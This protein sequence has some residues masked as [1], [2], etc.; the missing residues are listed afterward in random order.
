MNETPSLSQ[1]VQSAPPSPSGV[2]RRQYERRVLH[3]TAKLFLS[4]S[5]QDSKRPMLVRTSDVSIGGLAVVAPVNLKKD[6]MLVV[7]FAVPVRNL[8]A[9]DLFL[10][11]QV[12]HSVLARDVDGF[13]VGLRFI[14]IDAKSQ[15]ILRE[16]V[17]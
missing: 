9:A 5:E 7:R 10:H 8:P 12:M 16:F 14:N 13:K 3:T 4:D 15:D 17:A 2:E 1:S 11:V 6:V